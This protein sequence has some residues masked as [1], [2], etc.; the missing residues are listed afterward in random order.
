MLVGVSHKVYLIIIIGRFIHTS[1]CVRCQFCHP[2]I[3]LLS[4]ILRQVSLYQQLVLFVA[5]RVILLA[6]SVLSEDN[7]WTGGMSGAEVTGWVN[8]SLNDPYTFWVQSNENYIQ[9]MWIQ[10]YDFFLK[11]TTS[12]RQYH[13]LRLDEASLR[14]Y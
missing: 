5:L 1:S 4:C 2:L 14:M 6:L 10:V 7:L 12:Q 3:L 13:S 11:A 9:K 8:F